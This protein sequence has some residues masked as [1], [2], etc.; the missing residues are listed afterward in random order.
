MQLVPALRAAGAALRRDPVGVLPYYLAGLGV[1]LVGQTVV[2][3]GVVLAYALLS[4]TGR[5]S[6]FVD[7]LAEVDFDRLDPTGTDPA[8]ADPSVADPAAVQQLGEALALLVTPGTVLLA[9]GT[10]LLAVVLV[11]VANGVAG[12][13][14]IHAVRAALAGEPALA[15]GLVGAGRD[16]WRFVRLTLL[17]WTL[18]GLP[19]AVAVAVVVALAAVS[20]ALGLVVALL[21]TPLLL[22]VL[23]AVHV[24]LLFVPQA[25][26]VDDVG[27]LG[28]V[29]RN[30]GFVRANPL[31]AVGFLVLEVGAVVA[32]GTLTGTTALLSVPQLGALASL[33][34]VTPFLGLFRTA[35]YLD[36]DAVAGSVAGGP[37]PGDRLRAAGRRSWR[38]LVGFVRG[39]PVPVVAALAVFLLGAAGGWQ[40]TS[41][42]GLF[43][44]EAPAPGEAFGLV[45][46]DDFVN[47]AANNWRVAVGQA[48]AG[49]AVGVPTVG[50]L[51]FNG[52]LVGGLAGLG[53]DPRVFLALVAPH[54]ILEVPALAVAGG[55]GLAL[56][57]DA[58]R[59]LRGRSDADALAASVERAF[60]VLLGLLP[61]FVVAA[62][63]E[64]FVTP[65]VGALVAAG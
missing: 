44:P 52:L 60:Y 51:L 55:L 8:A 3:V 25:I 34:V 63:I 35:V 59:Y 58:W 50:N 53:Y 30:L 2:L 26:V 29:R 14:Q 41:G 15:P 61:V 1:G 37:G 40:A 27:V 62:A 39:H 36:A 56:G 64:A 17:A 32:S 57:R 22:A 28:G 20:P 11:V 10:V 19:V 16:A 49:L 7:A 48:F 65:W 5:L 9:A 47:I 21:G 18:Y 13:A 54:G 45:P 42:L 31:T 12:A 4:A 23:L 38:E 46:V 6:R 24:L 43:S 33:L